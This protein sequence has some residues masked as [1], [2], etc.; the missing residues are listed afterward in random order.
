MPFVI[1]G[2]KCSGKLTLIKELCNEFYNKVDTIC[3]ITDAEEHMHQVN[4]IDYTFITKQDFDDLSRTKNLAVEWEENGARYGIKKNQIE[5]C[6]KRSVISLIRTS[7]AG[8]AAMI[9]RKCG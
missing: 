3:V 2:T 4:N 1:V 7:K 5:T 6:K 8:A 9:E